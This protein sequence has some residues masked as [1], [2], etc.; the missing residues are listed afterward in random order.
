[1]IDGEVL[2]KCAYGDVHMNPLA[3]I[4]IGDSTLAVEAGPTD[5]LPVCSVRERCT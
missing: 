1:M 5:Q 4:E 2:I 3:E